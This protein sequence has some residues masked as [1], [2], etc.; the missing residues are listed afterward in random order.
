MK[1]T[2]TVICLILTL[3]VGAVALS[4][5]DKEEYNVRIEG[6][7]WVFDNVLENVGGEAAITECSESNAEIYPEAKVVEIK[8]SVKSGTLTVEHVTAGTTSVYV[9]AEEEYIE[10]KSSIY[11]LEDEEGNEAGYAT[12]GVT[13]YHDGSEEYTL[14]IRTGD[15]YEY[16]SEEIT[17]KE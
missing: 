15:R 1:K 10:G 2:V 3:V 9:L 11:I 16:F 14:I 7:E 6:H 17:D 4:A 8:V 5:C 13:S 12:I